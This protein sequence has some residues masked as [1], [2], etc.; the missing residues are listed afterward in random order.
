LNK[1]Y[2]I[3]GRNEDSNSPKQNCE[4]RQ[5]KYALN[6]FSC[7]GCGKSRT[8]NNVVKDDN[9]KDDNVKNHI[10]SS[11][12]LLKN[13]SNPTQRFSNSLDNLS[14]TSR[15]NKEERLSR[16]SSYTKELEE[17]VLASGR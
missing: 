6:I 3:E 14:T 16:H 1:R 8:T 13:S 7:F 5:K 2:L 15:L 12:N 11:S 4:S 9:I 17:E 10:G